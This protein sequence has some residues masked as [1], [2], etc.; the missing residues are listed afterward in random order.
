MDERLRRGRVC[1][2]ILLMSGL[3]EDAYRY[4]LRA[5]RAGTYLATFRAVARKYPHKTAS[6]ILHDLV[7]TMPGDEGKWFAAAKE[8]GLYGEAL[9]LASASA[10]RAGDSRPGL[11][12]HPPAAPW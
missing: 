5:N 2:D 6:E 8:A 9:A 10:D 7:R 4:G 11:G 12:S 1:E 3:V